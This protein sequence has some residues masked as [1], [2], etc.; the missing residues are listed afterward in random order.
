[1]AYEGKRRKI[2][3]PGQKETD[4]GIVGTVPIFMATSDDT[5]NISQTTGVVWNRISVTY[6]ILV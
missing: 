2:D 1:M 4:G 6:C 5:W 3:G